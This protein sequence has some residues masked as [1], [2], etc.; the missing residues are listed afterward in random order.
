MGTLR[1]IWAFLLFLIL[2]SI[3]VL[4]CKKFDVVYATSTPLTVGVPALVGNF[5]RR[6][7]YVIEIRDQW[8]QPFIDRGVLRNKLAIRFLLGLEKIIYVKSESI[9]ALSPGM[10]EGI[11]GVLLDIQKPIHV[12]P[13]CSDV[14]R[15]DLEMDCSDLRSKYAWIDKMVFLHAGAMGKAN[16][17]D[18]LINAANKLKDHP[19][20][21][22]VLLGK[23][24]EKKRLQ[25]MA[26]NMQLQNVEFLDFVP[27][28][29]LPY[30]LL[31]CDVSMVIFDDY[32][33]L[34]HNSANKFFDSLAAGKP[35]LINYSGWQREVLESHNAGFGCKR[36][37]MDEFVEK[38]LFLSSHK[39]EILKM[40]QN[41]RQVAI[42]KFPRDK[43]AIQ[44]LEAITSNVNAD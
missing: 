23:G 20:I 2:S 42:E 3:Y 40:G 25:E 16:G 6:F 5:I 24:S 35:V 4:F 13:N 11:R 26:R 29:D 32:P 27:K 44:A 36:W 30:Y 18:F 34:E 28:A 12:V 22:F 14:D 39:D 10:A 17:L 9:V 33:I 21:H 8:P 43:L 38:V 1:R 7:P 41:A 15:Y 31:A 37:D 19:N